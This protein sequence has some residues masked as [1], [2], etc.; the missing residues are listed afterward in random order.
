MKREPKRTKIIL[1]TPNEVSNE[2]LK[3]ISNDDGGTSI[4]LVGMKKKKAL[5]TVLEK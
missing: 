5:K 2:R 1:S 4:N 3:Y